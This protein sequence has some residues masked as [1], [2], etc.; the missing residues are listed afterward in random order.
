MAHGDDAREVRIA[1]NN[2]GIFGLL[3]LG[4][5]IGVQDVAQDPKPLTPKT[6]FFNEVSRDFKLISTVVGNYSALRPRPAGTIE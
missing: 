3:G 4:S 6:W 1:R 2:H 5:D